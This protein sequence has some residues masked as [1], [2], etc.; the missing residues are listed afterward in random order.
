MGHMDRI[1]AKKAQ[2]SRQGEKSRAT[3]DERGD[4]SEV[5]IDDFATSGSVGRSAPST[6]HF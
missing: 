6:L 2:G 4:A 3:P 5:K 1:R